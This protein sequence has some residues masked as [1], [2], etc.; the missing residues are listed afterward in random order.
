[1]DECRLV[2]VAVC[3]GCVVESEWND[4]TLAALLF[5]FLS[6]GLAVVVVLLLLVVVVFANDVERTRTIFV[7]FCFVSFRFD[8]DEYC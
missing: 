3:R 5:P 8:E 1:M 7:L 2:C 6:G 4:H